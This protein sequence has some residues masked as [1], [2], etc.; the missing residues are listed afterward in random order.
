MLGLSGKSRN[1]DNKVMRFKGNANDHLQK[2]Y[3][4]SQ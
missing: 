2:S 3:K 4:Q 1:P